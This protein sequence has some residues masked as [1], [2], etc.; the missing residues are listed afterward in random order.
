MFDCENDVI[1]D[2]SPEDWL[3]S[4]SSISSSQLHSSS[5][6]SDCLLLPDVTDA[7][8]QFEHSYSTAYGD[9]QHDTGT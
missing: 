7:S 2:V 8:V 1:S 5:L 6:L 3:E 4:I 9:I